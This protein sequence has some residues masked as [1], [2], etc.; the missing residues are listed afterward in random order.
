[1]QIQRAT[2]KDTEEIVQV[3]LQS[4]YA[5]PPN[6]NALKNTISLFKD[7]RERIF[8]AKEKENVVGYISLRKDKNNVGDIGFL[9]VLRTNHREGI[10]SKLMNYVEDYARENNYK[11]LVLVVRDS[12]QQ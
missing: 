3:E 12:N 9:A 10:T 11:G 6:F 8:I 5:H 1:M 2:A 7:K 4:G